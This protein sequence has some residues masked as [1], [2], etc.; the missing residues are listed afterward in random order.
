MIELERVKAFLAEMAPEKNVV[1]LDEG[2]HTS[3]LAAK[4]LNVEVGAIAKSILFVG[5]TN[6]VLVVA[7]GDV[8]VDDKKLAD[9]FGE[10]MKLGDTESVNRITGYAPG[11][12]CP[13]ALATPVPILL[14]ESMKRFD[15]L[16]TAGGTAHTAVAVTP[17]ELVNL[18]GGRW[19]RLAKE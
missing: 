11:G 5:K 10:R 2:I 19:A 4:A 13:F 3:A 18:T 9:I 14:D 12:V 17:D 6:H 15:T 8:R 7:S 1:E 16:Y